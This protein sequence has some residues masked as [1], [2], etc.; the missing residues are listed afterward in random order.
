MQFEEFSAGGLAAAIRSR[1]ISAREALD[2][3]YDRIDSINPLINAVITQCRERAYQ[4]ATRADEL[5]ASNSPL[6]PL[7]GVPMTH[8]DTHST[9]GI[10]TTQGSVVFRDAVPDFDD[11]IIERFRAAGVVSSGKSNVPE[12]A[13]GSHTFNELFGTTVN[14]YAL[15]RS[16]GGSSG[17]AAATI[18]SRIQPLGDGSDMGGS[19]RNP[20]AFCNIV[21]FRPSFGVLPV[22]PSRDAWAWLSRTGPM[23]RS[24]T[25][26]ALAMSVLAGP[27]PRIP[28]S[29]PIDPAEFAA[30]A[31]TPSRWQ[32]SR[33]PLEGTRV[34]LSIDFGL[35]VPVEDEISRRLL[36]E[37]AVFVE[38]GADVRQACPD[39]SEADF[40]F[41]TTRAFDMAI[42]LG[43][44]VADYGD[45]VK[46]EVLWNVSKG[47]SL[48]ARDLM[49]AAL[50]RT[51]VHLA[52]RNFFDR[53]DILLCPTTQ[54]LPFDAGQR[55]PAI[56][57]GIPM[58]NYTSWMRS[59]SLIS[60]TGCPAISVPAGFSTSGLPV[61]LQMVAARGN[62][63]QLLRVA[64]EY[65][66][67]T[68]YANE[69]PSFRSLSANKGTRN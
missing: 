2:A 27:D 9:A 26:I 41:D 8:K 5:T 21:G 48:T 34:G 12:F 17:G 18:A 24:V 61:G 31:A 14:P 44:I 16:A 35:D 67:A 64:R 23:A 29:C 66:Q 32:N 52:V 30:A 28:T 54:A 1:E 57:R 25:D 6:P 55:F 38:L 59:A 65:E 42:N 60:A 53:F 37:T 15:D 56:V 49:D 11:L 40:V 43:Q 69:A 36:A 47:L 13:A 7:H 58:R 46:P 20:A 3:H 68:C 63:V 4:Q 19:L 45:V 62:D 10:R 33:R 51:R 39:L 22:A 50:A